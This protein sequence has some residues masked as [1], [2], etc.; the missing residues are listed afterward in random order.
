MASVFSDAKGNLS[1]DYLEKNW[2]INTGHY[3]YILYKLNGEIHG[4]KADLAK[5]NYY[6]SI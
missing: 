2:G 1:I 6:S 4:K 3:L 5:I